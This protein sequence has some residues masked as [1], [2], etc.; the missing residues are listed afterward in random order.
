MNG[1]VYYAPAAVMAIALGFKLPALTRAWRDPL[2]R[3]VCALL[4]L[5]GMV[6]FFAAPPTIH[7]VNRLTGIPNFSAPLVYALL[8]A[9]SASCLVLIVNW[10]GG[11]PEVTRRISR[12]W[13]AGYS[14]VIVALWVL[15]AL[16]DAPVERL[17]DLDTYYCSTP[18]IREMIL[19]YLAA[20]TVAGFAMTILCWRW[21]LR[22][23]GWLRTGLV[24]IV[25]GYLFNIAYLV[26]KFSAVFARWAGHDW[27]ELSSSV[28]PVLASAGAQ[29]SAVGFCLPLACQRMADAWSARVTYRRLEPLWGELASVAPP[30]ARGVRLFWWSSGELRVTQRE[31]DIHDGMLILYPYFDARVRDDA[32]EAALRAG[33]DPAQA[34]AEADAAMV[35]AAV[36]ARAADPEGK[37][38]CSAEGS[39][40]AFEPSEGPRDLVRMSLAMRQSPVVAAAR[41]R[42]AR[43]ESQFH[44]R[45]R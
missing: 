43:Q 20:L 33:S 7:E 17:R 23:R 32:Y 41:G 34:Q 35:T 28:A 15:F 2:L 16:G 9:F 18:Y 21:S 44:E 25:I 4:A 12:R 3:S 5:A 37:I 8:S 36:R 39:A 1:T 22:V 38:I 6:F 24:I 29:V 10:R 40:S 26:T 27:D 30:H 42:A 14:V 45:T 13:I 11:P 19:L 31:S